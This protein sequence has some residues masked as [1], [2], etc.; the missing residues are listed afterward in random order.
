MP[1]ISSRILCLFAAVLLLATACGGTSNT[2]SS[3][4]EA[5]SDDAVGTMAEVSEPDQ[6]STDDESVGPDESES[7]EVASGSDDENTE[8]TL[9]FAHI[10]NESHPFHACGIAPMAEALADAD[11]GIT[12]EVFPAAQLGS[13][14]ENIQNIVGGNLEMSIV[15]FGELSTFHPPISVLDANYV[16]DDFDHMARTARGEIGQELFD[17]LRQVAPIETLDL[18]T[19]GV[20]QV[21]SNT[22]VSSPEDLDGL[23]M[24][25]IESPIGLAN[26]RTL[27]A[28]PT[29]VAFPEL[30]LGLQQGVVDGQE[31]PISIIDAASLYEVQDYVNL[32]NH[33]VFAAAVVI[34]QDI[35][36]SMST[37]QQELL[38]QEVLAAGDRD[39]DC[40][41]EGR[42][43]ILARWQEEGL[44]EVNDE[45][46]I[47]AFRARAEAELP[48]EFED[49]WGDL[50]EQ[51]REEA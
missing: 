23:K 5:E 43:D 49:V 36:N 35:W 33:A 2:E 51:I 45:V 21:T 4:T 44:I 24:R 31:N 7:E 48:Q 9:R 25:A 29:P 41:E 46:D 13:N 6:Q 18:W 20:R 37:G 11:M 22:P 39:A 30:Y 38:Q 28:E 17:G 40:V 16:F 15:G 32:T 42:D 34:N 10:V 47:D 50:Y 8:V 3:S 19:G 12:M 14:Q 26:V 27:G 1:S